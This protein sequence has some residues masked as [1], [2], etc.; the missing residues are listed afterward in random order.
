MAVEWS[1]SMGKWVLSKLWDLWWSLRMKRSR[2]HFYDP[3]V[4]YCYSFYDE[5]ENH[6]RSGGTKM[7]Y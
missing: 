6:V 5:N 2:L 3:A 7:I 1:V 4:T